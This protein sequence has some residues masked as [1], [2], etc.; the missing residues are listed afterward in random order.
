M[1]AIKLF[2]SQSCIIEIMLSTKYVNEVSRTKEEAAV[3]ME[4]IKAEGLKSTFTLNYM[5]NYKHSLHAAINNG[6]MVSSHCSDARTSYHKQKHRL[7]VLT[8]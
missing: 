3:P 1:A 8:E 5:T 6:L 2:L 7:A 4:Y